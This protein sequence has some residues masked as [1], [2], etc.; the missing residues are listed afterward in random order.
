ML[1]LAIPPGGWGLLHR[2]RR[3]RTRASDPGGSPLEAGPG[4]GRP[5]GGG[6]GGRGG[7]RRAST[8][9]DP[10]FHPRR[11]SPS[12]RTEA[13]MLNPGGSPRV[14]ERARIRP[15]REPKASQPARGAALVVELFGVGHGAPGAENGMDT[16]ARTVPRLRTDARR[17][18]TPGA[19]SS[20]ATPLMIG[21]PPTN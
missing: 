12:I 7:G 17:V 5:L 11:S 14:E 15:A 6:G 1:D 10:P 16:R 19:S 20:S 2:A 18:G 13:A 21:S 8:T 4:P 9:A 3:D